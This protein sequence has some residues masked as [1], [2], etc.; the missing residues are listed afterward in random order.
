MG[1]IARKITGM[2]KE[3][4]REAEFYQGERLAGMKEYMTHLREGRKRRDRKYIPKC[5]RKK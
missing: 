1:N 3:E 4:L 2:T 5:I